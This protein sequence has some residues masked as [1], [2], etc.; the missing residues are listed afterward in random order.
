M[1]R[2]VLARGGTVHAPPQRLAGQLHAV[3]D[4][5]RRQAQLEQAADR[6][7]ARCPRKR[8]MDLPTGSTPQAHVAAPVRPRCRVARSHR[9]HA[10]RARGAQSTGHTASQSRAPALARAKS[11]TRA[12]RP[13][14]DGC[15]SPRLP[16]VRPSQIVSIPRQES[17][18]T[19]SAGNERSNYRRVDWKPPGARRDGRMTPRGWTVGFGAIGT[20]EKFGAI[21]S[22][23]MVCGVRRVEW[24]GHVTMMKRRT[25][26]G[27]RAPRGRDSRAPWRSC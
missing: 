23:I 26:D 9:T 3:A 12:Q 4:A 17:R 5:Q 18:A 16:T 11:A 13:T 24:R 19:N 20:T 7:S 21:Y 27:S 10:A 2:A 8:S 15:P 6:T 25:W 1:R 14:A 22:R